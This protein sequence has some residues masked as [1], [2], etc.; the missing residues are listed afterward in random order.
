MAIKKNKKII[1]QIEKV[2]MQNNKNWMELLRIAIESNPTASRRV[3]KSININDKKISKL[4]SK[5][6]L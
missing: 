5:I 1:N 4:L 3:L 6:N 2:R